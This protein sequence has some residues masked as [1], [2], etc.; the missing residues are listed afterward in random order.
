MEPSSLGSCFQIEGRLISVEPYGSG[1]IHDTYLGTYSRDGT[2]ARYIHQHIN[3]SVFA[4]P[5][6]L[7]DNACRITTH[8]RHKLVSAG[9]DQV[10]RRVLQLVPSLEGN[11]WYMDEDGGYWRTFYFIEATRTH[12]TVR[13]VEQAFEAAQAFGRFQDQLNDL[14]GT[15]A[16]TI[17]DFHNTPACFR[18]LSE[19]LDEDLHNRAAEARPAVDFVEARS[20]LL[21]TLENLAA[22]GD[23]P[24]RIAHNDTK[25]N[26][27][28]FDDVSREALAVIDLDTVMPGL[29]LYDFGDLV[30]TAASSAPE[31]ETDLS[32]VAINLSMFEA[33]VRGYLSAAG[34]LSRSEIDHLAF[35]GWLLSMESGIRFLTDYLKGDTYFKVHRDKHNLDRCRAQLK[36]AE[37][38]ERNE[39]AMRR[40]VELAAP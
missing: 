37:D 25:I 30:R 27:V 28:L 3:G 20:G 16:V 34:F 29:V 14:P 23:L 24:E 18:L 6:D 4:Q 5:I 38:I 9:A 40:I 39:S 36:L 19:T 17:P 21:T 15:L 1:H 11:Q 31:D 32:R 12:D 33:L 13:F 35:S 26:N 22:R 7:V 8:I 10:E 2:Q